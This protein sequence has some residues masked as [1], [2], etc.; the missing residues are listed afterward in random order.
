MGN[1]I[2][3]I[4]EARVK[5]IRDYKLPKTKADLKFFLDLLSYYR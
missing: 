3:A 2:V 5:A 1:E 4:Q